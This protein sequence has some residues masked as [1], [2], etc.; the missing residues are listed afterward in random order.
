MSDIM[1]LFLVLSIIAITV[2]A[3]VEKGDVIKDGVG[4]GQN[5]IRID[6]TER[7]IVCYKVTSGY[8]VALSCLRP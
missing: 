6:D 7:G 8:G 2:C 4:I 5:V 3:C 1:K